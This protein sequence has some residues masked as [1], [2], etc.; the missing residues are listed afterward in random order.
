MRFASRENTLIGQFEVSRNMGQRVAEVARET[1]AWTEPKGRGL[2]LVAQ[3]RVG[4][5][6]NFRRTP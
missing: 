3:R 6:D 1:G 2:R 5:R 4:G